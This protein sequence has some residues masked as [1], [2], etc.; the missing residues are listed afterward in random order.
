VSGNE[1]RRRKRP[2][3]EEQKQDLREN[4]LAKTGSVRERKFLIN[5]ASLEGLS[6]GH[7]AEIREWLREPDEYAKRNKGFWQA[8]KVTVLGPV[9]HQIAK[10]RHKKLPLGH[11]WD[12]ACLTAQGVKQDEI[13]QL[14]DMSPRTVDNVILKIK[15]II[16]QDLDCEIESVN[17]AQI[18]NWFLGL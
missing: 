6:E 5:W 12:V 17:L 8:A 1:T 15:Q 18:S 14:M 9:L 4:W 10:E 3:T 16:V 7:R 13:A 11:E 2:L